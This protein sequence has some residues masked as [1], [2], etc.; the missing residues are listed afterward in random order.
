MRGL[1]D[2]RDRLGALPAIS[3][4]KR[5]ARSSRGPSGAATERNGPSLRLAALAALVALAAL[6]AQAQPRVAVT[7]VWV[8]GVPGAGVESPLV[9]PA[10]SLPTCSTGAAN[11]PAGVYA[12]GTALLLGA[13]AGGFAPGW[14]L[15][16]SGAWTRA[17]RGALSALD[18][19]PYALSA[20]PLTKVAFPDLADA[21]RDALDDAFVSARVD[22]EAIVLAD[23]EDDETRLALP[24]GGHLDRGEVDSRVGALAR[25]FALRATADAAARAGIATLMGGASQDA[26]RLAYADLRGRPAIPSNSDIDG[27][28]L[29]PARTGSA[30]RWAPAKLPANVAYG[31]IRT[32][33][34]IDGRILPA[35]RMGNTDRWLPAKL[36]A[37]LAYGTIRSDADIDNRILAPAR[38]GNTDPWGRAKLPA[39]AVYADTQRFT[40][41]LAAKLGT[42]DSTD[43]DWLFYEDHHS[44]ALA[45]APWHQTGLVLPPDATG[46][47]L[48]EETAT[49]CSGAGVI[50]AVTVAQL[51]GLAPGVGG[52]P[53]AMG[54]YVALPRPGGR[55]HLYVG[56]DAGGRILLA[57]DAGQP[58]ST[59]SFDVQRRRM[60]AWADARYPFQL[61]PPSKLTNQAVWNVS[62]LPT[63]VHP[64][65]PSVTFEV[66][67]GQ[68]AYLAPHHYVNSRTASPQSFTLTMGTSPVAGDDDMGFYRHRFGSVPD[69]LDWLEAL[70]HDDDDQRLKV[71][72]RTLQSLGPSVRVVFGTLG[73]FT[74]AR[75]GRSGAVWSGEAPMNAPT[76]ATQAI[77]LTFTHD[78]L[79][80]EREEEEGAGGGALS[81]S[82]FSDA[83]NVRFSVS[84]GVV[85]GHVDLPKQQEG[86]TVT[87]YTATPVAGSGY[88]AGVTTTH[89]FTADG[90]ALA[91]QSIGDLGENF[92]VL[93][94][95]SNT[96]REAFTDLS[97]KVDDKPALHFAEARRYAGSNDSDDITSYEWRTT[98]IFTAGSQSTISI[99]EQAKP[100]ASWAQEGDT[101]LVPAAKLGTGTAN[102]TKVLHGD[103]TWQDAPTGGGT[104]GLTTAQVDNRILAPARTGNADR[105]GKGKLPADVAYGTIPSNADIDNRILPAARAGS[106]ARW[107]KDKLPEDIGYEDVDSG[108][109]FPT[110]GVTSGKEFDLLVAQA[111]VAFPAQMTSGQSL[112]GTG[113]SYGWSKGGFG[114]VDTATSAV[115]GFWWTDNTSTVAAADRDRIHITRASGETRAVT[116]YRYK[117]AGGAFAGAIQPVAQVGGAHS[118]VFRGTTEITDN[119]F[120]AGSI[121][122]VQVY[123]GG[124]DERAFPA[125]DYEPH[126]YKADAFLRWERATRLDGGD[127]V[128]LLSGLAGDD[129][130]SADAIRDFPARTFDR[131]LRIGPGTGIAITSAG[132]DAGS[133]FELLSPPFDL[134]DVDHGELA[135]SAR[136]SISTRSAANVKI[137]AQRLDEVALTDIA[138]AS[139]L[140]DL[141]AHSA[142]DTATWRV[143]GN[144]VPVTAGGAARGDL[145]LYLAR[146][147]ANQVGYRLAYDSTAAGSENLSVALTLGI[148]WSPTDDGNPDSLDQ[149]EVDAR[150]GALTRPLAL[151]A[152]TDTAARTGVAA[153]MN[154]APMGNA[155]ERLNYASLT[156]A[157][158]VDARADDRITGSVSPFALMGTGAAAVRRGLAA[159][160]AGPAANDERLD[161]DDLKNKPAIPA[162]GGGGALLVELASVALAT[163]T[164][165]IN[166]GSGTAP[167]ANL[168]TYPL[169]IVTQGYSPTNQTYHSGPAIRALAE[170]SLSAADVGGTLKNGTGSRQ[171][172][173]VDQVNAGQVTVSTR[174][175][176]NS[177]W[178][179][180]NGSA[181]FFKLW[182][183]KGGGGAAPSA[184][185]F[186][187]KELALAAAAGS[188]TTPGSHTNR[189][190]VTADTQTMVVSDWSALTLTAD[191]TAVGGVTASTSAITFA[192][193]G[194]AWIEG[195]FEFDPSHTG[196]G[197]RMLNSIRGALTRGAATTRPASMK[198]STFYVK[199][200]AQESD[201]RQGPVRQHAEFMWLFDAQAGDTIALEWRAELQTNDVVDLVAAD[202]TITVRIFN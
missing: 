101:S 87:S 189:K 84:G 130:L 13:T 173:D 131:V 28:I 168:S 183:V 3:G 22:G 44:Q 102:S 56:E 190:V 197:A 182:G 126:R 104:G 164:S 143:V 64:I 158:D 149:A 48:C 93:I 155:A 146:N 53:K 124:Q 67:L 160:L 133:A 151:V 74:L 127:V 50:G 14:L 119:P 108:N 49:Q 105:W 198:S 26:G 24:I 176:P 1:A 154:A 37:N 185:A 117:A 71:R 106:T 196:G 192:T 175:P 2:T 167:I 27:R 82:E 145:R 4:L 157:P 85:E 21:P 187:D 99:I 193:A 8:Q 162:G 57:Q 94:T 135:V 75:E 177:N 65:H 125:K 63:G 76:G 83:G 96:P 163:G 181:R 150:V 70:Y 68:A 32:N 107:G 25:P 178:P 165:T 166:F 137:G 72:I 6:A 103:G 80:W 200:A 7:S 47:E 191:S 29:A 86:E 129:R 43:G 153:L 180:A 60:P 188:T 184:P 118:H 114:A 19:K 123:L 5:P 100:A 141:A 73:T 122:I 12:E 15:C 194:K 78:I 88:D 33:S 132:S 144:P 128:R 9:L 39:D 179:S 147:A 79:W 112:G 17:E 31:T 113:D 95:P 171:W 97:L 81:Q 42:L 54:Q 142:A 35:A 11:P 199:T 66:P 55:G 92:I 91:I 174:N 169:L 170:S 121:A 172:I 186:H 62:S 45:G 58:A 18:V 161:Y 98:D 10:R 148:A 202:S 40:D 111:D 52:S 120:P 41:A 89:N 139:D 140:R 30:A 134:D 34:D 90:R 46:V 59:V 36:P 156:G 201:N 152:T 115:T 195:S 109:T 116:G 77:T 159:A 136:L 20:N 16:E 69:G 51:D 110:T 138:F 61:I 23:H 38:T